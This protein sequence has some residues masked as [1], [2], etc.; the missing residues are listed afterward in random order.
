MSKCG[1]HESWKDYY[2]VSVLRCKWILKEIDKLDETEDCWAFGFNKVGEALE[3]LKKMD[4]G[5]NH[6]RGW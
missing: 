4:G 5:G 2:D 6:L 1:E 3:A